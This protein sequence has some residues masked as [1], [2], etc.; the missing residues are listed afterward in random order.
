[1]TAQTVREIAA[2]GFTDAIEMLGIIE[3]LEAGNQKQII[4]GLNEAGAGRAAE[5]IKRALFTRLHFLVARA[6]GITRRKDRNT[7]KA[8][9]ILNDPKVAKEMANESDLTEAQNRWLKC[10]GDDRLK[11]FIHFRDKYLAHLG[12]P[13]P[14]VAFPT[15]GDVFALA[16]ETAVVLEKLA[17]AAGVVTL[18]LDTQV[19]AHKTSAEKFWTIWR[20]A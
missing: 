6:Y 7:R 13:E 18:S 20:K 11:A 14:D 9:E 4:Q 1:M 15:Y 3:V 16:R 19:P 8:F 12:E 17:H 2:S 5:H 10:C